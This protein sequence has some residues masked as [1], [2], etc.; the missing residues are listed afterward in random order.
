MRLAKYL[1]HCGVASR[2]ASEE[3]VRAGRVTITGEVVRDPA[4][5]VTDGEEV[6][7]DGRLVRPEPL[8]VWALNKPPGVLSTVRDTHGR[9]TVVELVPSRRRLYPVGRLDA[10]STGLLLLTNDGELAELV[11][12][13]RYGVERVYHVRVEPPRFGQRLVERLQRGV[14]LEDGPARALRARA[15][16]RG[17]LEITMGEGRKREVRRMLDA[18][19]YRVVELERVRIGPLTLQSLGLAPGE[20]RRLGTREIDALRRA[21]RRPRRRAGR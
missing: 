17:R 7:V 8:E 13:P 3:L 4:R 15:I 16:G 14:E 19:G 9:K 18:L 6:R 20:S 11:M 5:A 10:D 21:A 12:H 2:R 1:A